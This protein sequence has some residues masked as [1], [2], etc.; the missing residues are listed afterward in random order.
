M[1]LVP[2]NRHMGFQVSRTAGDQVDE[3]CRTI[4]FCP[5]WFVQFPIY[6]DRLADLVCLYIANNR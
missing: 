2:E 5:A 1:L 4:G 6:L 3:T